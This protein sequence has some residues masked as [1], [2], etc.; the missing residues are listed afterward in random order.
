MKIVGISGSPRDGNSLWLLHEVLTIAK[1]HG[2]NIDLF[3]LSDLK[4]NYCDGCLRCE[5]T[6][7][8]SQNDDMEFVYEV[9]SD[10]DTIVIATPVYFDNI[11]GLL[12]I[13]VDRLN[14]LC[15]DLRGKNLAAIVVGQLSGE[16]GVL[17]KKA[18]VDYIKNVCKIFD[19]NF[20]ASLELTARD[21]SDAK[22]T[23]LIDKL[24][25]NFATK[26]MGGYLGDK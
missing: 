21:K 24:I 7:S 6:K 12:K 25:L 19:L 3:R 26:L 11:S 10:C 9:L 2:N 1:N 22:R 5:E 23:I 17:S 15:G 16:E 8:C 14:P 18:T 4:I 13:F 20:I